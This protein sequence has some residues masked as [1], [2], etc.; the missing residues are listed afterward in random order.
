MNR[1]PKVKQASHWLNGLLL[2]ALM[3]GS[4]GAPSAAQAQTALNDTPMFSNIIVP[5][6]V[7]LALSVEWPTATSRAHTDPYAS[8][9]T[10]IGYF[11]PGKCYD[12]DNNNGY[13]APSQA[14]NNHVCSGQWSGNFLNWATRQ[15]LTPSAGR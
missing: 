9:S 8:S 13:F 15:P 3:L 5:S 6:N 12:Y 10:F 14:A 11:D 1:I 7:L 2:A 4:V